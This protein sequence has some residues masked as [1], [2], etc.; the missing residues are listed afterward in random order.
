MS[1]AVGRARWGREQG[2]HQRPMLIRYEVIHK[3]RHGAGS[4]QTT[5]KG[6]KRRLRHTAVDVRLRDE[7]GL[8]RLR[9]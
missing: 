4:C 7:K 3:C 9:A 1:A 5:P 2:R 6:A 8:E